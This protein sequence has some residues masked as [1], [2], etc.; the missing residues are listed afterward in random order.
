MKVS[1]S[2]LSLLKGKEVNPMGEYLFGLVQ[3]FVGAFVSATA[4]V[5][6]K[7]MFGKKGK[8]KPTFTPNNRNKG[9]KS[10]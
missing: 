8:E 2:N 9:G 7:R 1:S 6:A 10:K 5:L 3:L 4:K